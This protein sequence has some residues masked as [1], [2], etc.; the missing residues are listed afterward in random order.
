[1]VIRIKLSKE[2]LQ[3]FE[4]FKKMVKP[5]EVSDVNFEKLIF[6][7]GIESINMA[8]QM[9]LEKLKA[10]DPEKFKQLLTPPETPNND[11]Q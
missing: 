3:A 2:E 6:M 10:E 1:M 8:I 7:R 9:E 4:N 11:A 5:P